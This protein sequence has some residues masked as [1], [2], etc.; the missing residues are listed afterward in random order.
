MQVKNNEIKV[1]IL[2]VAYNHEKYIREALDSVVMQ[3]TNFKFEAIIGEDK[4]TDNTRAIIREYQ[5][6]YPDIIKPI[7]REKNIGA[8]KN[9][10]S[11]LKRCTGE[12]IAFLECDDFWI[13][14]LK[15]QK[16]VDYMEKH[17]ECAGV[18]SGVRVVNRYSQGMVTG[19]KV[20]DYEL[21]T[22]F[23]FVKTMYPYNQFKFIGC[24]LT[25]NYYVN[26]EYNKYFLKTKYVT[27]ITF[28]AISILHGKIGFV[29]ECMSAYRWVPSNGSNFSALKKDILSRDKIISCRIVKSMFPVET[30]KWIYM[31]ICRE[32]WQLIH[33]YKSNERYSDV[34]RYIL[35]EMP[36]LEKIFCI[37]YY[38]TRKLTGVY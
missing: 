28:M 15:L 25:R 27:D 36:F 34:L 35:Q 11:T 13:D 5:Q 33:W 31:R 7:F 37:I 14:P 1:S 10:V 38:V 3:Q 6:K 4:S 17:S 24:F 12:Y 21:R 8:S 30:H 23:D 32:H 2:M 9:V 19:P 20:L 22:P 16:Q 18:I 26:G 29:S